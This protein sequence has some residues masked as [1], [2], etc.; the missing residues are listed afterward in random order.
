MSKICTHCGK[1]FQ[2]HEAFCGSCGNK[3]VEKAPN[4]EIP[5]VPQA[6]LRPELNSEPKLRPNPV[7]EPK[8]AKNKNRM[9][10]IVAVGV[11]LAILLYIFIAPKG[12]ALVGKWELQMGSYDSG[13][14][15]EFKKNGTYVKEMLDISEKGRYKLIDGG[16]EGTFNIIPDDIREDSEE[17]Q[18]RIEDDIL[19]CDGVIFKKVK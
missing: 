19:D 12:N 6:E 8:P 14:F 1:E 5:K 9:I 17:V 4:T 10:G 3:L 18:Y 7:P 2:Q 16:K 11:V 13:I 15:I